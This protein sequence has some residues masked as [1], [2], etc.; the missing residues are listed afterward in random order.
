MVSIQPSLMRVP[1][2]RGTSSW[3]PVPS[4]P[5]AGTRRAATSQAGRRLRGEG[6]PDGAGRSWSGVVTGRACP[7]RPR[8]ALIGVGAEITDGH[9][10]PSALE[11]LAEV[12]APVTHTDQDGGPWSYR[13]GTVTA[14]AEACG[15]ASWTDGTF[16]GTEP[17]SA[18][19]SVTDGHFD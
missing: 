1:V 12:G 14:C 17:R 5:I 19:S 8:V 18:T 15:V 6:R 7:M 2:S 3:S 16:T 11:T 10:A 4:S 13:T 9:P